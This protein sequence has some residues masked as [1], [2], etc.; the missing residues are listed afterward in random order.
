M[1][2]AHQPMTTL[3]KRLLNGDRQALAKAITLVESSREDHRKEAD[4]L[5]QKILLR[6]STPTIRIGLSGTPGA[7]KSTFIEALGTK[8]IEDGHKI[9]VLAIDPTSQKTGGSI[10]GDK[11]RMEKLSREPN[12]FIRPSP[13]K[14][15]LGGVTPKTREVILLCETAGYDVVIVETVG[16][17]QSEIAASE[18]TDIFCLIITPAGGDELQGLK[19]GITENAD[20]I[21][22]N[23]A[24]GELFDAA[25]MTVA[26]YSTALRLLGKR[27]NTHQDYPKVTMVS[28]TMGHGLNKLSQEIFKF[29]ELQRKASFFDKRRKIQEL[30]WFKEKSQAFLFELFSGKKDPIAIQRSLEKRIMKGD[31]SLMDAVEKFRSELSK[32]YK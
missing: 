30:I 14:L 4:D 12:A 32:I 19:R 13:S 22:V 9:G 25:N 16:V 7:G 8:L 5:V 29:V 28:S 1:R 11:T 27:D 2:L 23:K 6:K 17:G 26:Q 31:L 18:M 21:I 3:L 20:F 24:D 10:L 15:A